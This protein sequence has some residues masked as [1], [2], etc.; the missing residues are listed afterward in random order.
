MAKQSTKSA[1]EVEYHINPLDPHNINPRI[2]QWISELI[3]KR[4]SMTVSEEI[5]ALAAIARIQVNF[6]TLR[7]ESGGGLATGTEVKRFAEAF[8]ANAKSRGKNISGSAKLAALAFDDDDSD[9]D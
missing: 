7:E 3:E 5:R 2:Q 4:D 9:S 8:A 6:I 1:S